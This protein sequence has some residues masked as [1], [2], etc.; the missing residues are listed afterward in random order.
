M[1]K[2]ICLQLII[3]IGLMINSLIIQ[4]QHQVLNVSDNLY[5]IGVTPES[6]GCKGDG[7]TDDTENLQ[8][9]IDFCKD[10]CRLLRSSKGKIYAISRPLD[11]KNPGEMQIDFG[12]A[13]IRAIRT[14]DYMMNYDNGD[15]YSISHNNIIN[16]LLLDCNHLSGGIHCTEAIKTSFNFIMIRN[17]ARKA[18][19]ALNGYEIFL[20]NSH[21]H[22][23][24]DK[25]TY[26]IYMKTGDSHFD[27]IVIIDAHTAVF[28][29]CPA[30]NFYDKI[31]AWLFSHVGGSTFFSVAG[32]A[33][34]NQCYC[35]TAEKGY[36]IHR[37]AT[38]KITN[39]QYINNPDCYD[40][41]NHP[42]IFAFADENLAKI[43]NIGC[44]GSCFNAGGMRVDL[45]NYQ[46]QRI[47]FNQC[48]IDP[49]I[50]GNFGRFMVIPSEG[51]AFNLAEGEVSDDNFD[52]FCPDK[53]KKNH[54][55]VDANVL[56]YNRKKIIKVGS[57]Q[58]EYI[59]THDA[60]G[61]CVVVL[62]NGQFVHGT[63]KI[64]KANGNV[65]VNPGK[66]KGKT[67]KQIV[68]DLNYRY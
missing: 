16:N 59:P 47:Q 3:I 22:C 56:Y 30:V 46:S 37:F 11:L 18:F 25:T 57:I 44:I 31:H 41:S 62:E 61:L 51:I 55:Y 50:N 65:F 7:L 5:V 43:A 1:K 67:I 21:I 19:E 66:I 54:L 40:S 15:D 49:S 13:E 52:F 8:R 29:D 34:L 63:V 36:Y 17:C 33:L 28:N 12:G 26:G 14:M 20:T 6:F 64:C 32:Q 39:C 4:A 60:Y 48:F 24:S 58:K 35:D 45:C 68:I 9:A 23:D 42:V 53:D 10:N 38:L 2:N 27:N